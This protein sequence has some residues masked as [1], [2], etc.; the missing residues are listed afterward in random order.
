[1]KKKPN[2][3]QSHSLNVNA[4]YAFF[5]FCYVPHHLAINIPYVNLRINNDSDKTI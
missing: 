5:D 4:V 1:M 3:K 2:K